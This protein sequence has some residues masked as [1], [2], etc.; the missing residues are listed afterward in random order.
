MVSTGALQSCLPALWHAGDPPTKVLTSPVANSHVLAPV[1]HAHFAADWDA[2][3]CCQEAAAASR[4]LA[5]AA[6]V[7]HSHTS[8]LG[9]A[10]LHGLD[11]PH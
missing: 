3:H 6:Q 5:A 8:Q 9:L 4:A 2:L 1:S 11:G 7:Q 10:Q